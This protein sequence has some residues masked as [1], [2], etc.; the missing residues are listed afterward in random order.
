MTASALCSPP[1]SFVD[2][3]PSH[4]AYGGGE[5][6]AP[7]RPALFALTEQSQNHFVDQASSVQGRWARL[8]PTPASGHPAQVVVGDL[9]GFLASA[10]VAVGP[11]AEEAG[12][13]ATRR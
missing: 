1:P 9:H 12:Q 13:P 6:V 7:V 4:Q 8:E 3:D 10:N 5:V 2:E 11:A